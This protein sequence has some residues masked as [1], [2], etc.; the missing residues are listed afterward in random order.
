MIWRKYEKTEMNRND[1]D[2]QSSKFCAETSRINWSVATRATCSQMRREGFPFIIGGLGVG[3][4]SP[5]VGLAT[6]SV[7]RHPRYCVNS[8]PSGGAHKMRQNHL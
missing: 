4:C 3:L 7:R 2:L 8:L 5:I 1:L 6:A